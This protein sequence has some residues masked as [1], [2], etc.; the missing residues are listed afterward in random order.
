MGCNHIQDPENKKL[1]MDVNEAKNVYYSATTL[2]DEENMFGG[3][4]SSIRSLLPALNRISHTY[5]S[6]HMTK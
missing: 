6:S 2:R 1:N 4:S 3:L 5:L